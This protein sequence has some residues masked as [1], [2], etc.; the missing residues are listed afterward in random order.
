[1][2][3][4]EALDY[5]LERLREKK[6]ENKRL[7]T[8]ILLMDA[9]HIN[10]AQLFTQPEK[11]LSQDEENRFLSYVQARREG[12]PVQ[13][14]LGE[15]EFMGLPFFV[16]SHVLIPRPDTEI[17]TEEA[18]ARLGQGRNQLVLDIGTGSGCIAVSVAHYTK[19]R[20]YA[21]DISSE[22]LETA[23]KNAQRNQ[24]N[25]EF[26]QSDCFSQVP[27]CFMS[28]F[29]M[30]LSN[31][32]YITKQEMK[33]LMEE[34][35]NF[36]P[37][38]ALYGGE[39]GLDYYRRITDQAGRFLKPEGWL[40]YEIGCAQGEAVAEILKEQGFYNIQVKQDLSG[41]DRVVIGQWNKKEGV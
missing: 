23:K 4:G 28:S 1:M 36:E 21:V 33:D 18:I 10:R 15:W 16:N 27:E 24:V 39:D 40:I 25:V 14:I 20:V 30:I 34:V 35:V 19:A 31:P 13:Y 3:I 8:E 12:M 32:P 38:L 26:L 9:M 29:D 22:A 2:T 37:A 11:L 6:I 5:A 7:E 17:L 41:L